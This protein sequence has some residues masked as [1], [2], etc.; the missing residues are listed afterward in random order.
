M[1]AIPTD[2]ESREYYKY[3]QKY[4][5]FSHLD[6]YISD[7]VDMESYDDYLY[8]HLYEPYIDS[9]Y[10]YYAINY[11]GGTHYHEFSVEFNQHSLLGS[12]DFTLEFDAP[13]AVCT[14][15]SAWLP[16]Y[17]PDYTFRYRCKYKIEASANYDLKIK[18]K[19]AHGSQ[20][21]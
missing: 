1:P 20:L 16:I 17:T 4:Q 3:A 7:G 21:M 6:F 12:K 15:E 18:G 14:M 11:Y 9:N 5:L 10:Y 8:I 13:E 2:E 19:S